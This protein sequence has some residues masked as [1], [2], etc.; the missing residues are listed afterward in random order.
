M[1]SVYLSLEEAEIRKWY[2]H[3]GFLFYY[4]ALVVCKHKDGLMSNVTH[5]L[6]FSMA[7]TCDDSKNQFLNVIVMHVEWNIIRME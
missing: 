6:F 5:E 4:F 2:A 7:L 3:L 1:S